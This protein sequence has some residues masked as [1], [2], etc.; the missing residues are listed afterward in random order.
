MVHTLFELIGS[1]A[2]IEET[3]SQHETLT[4]SI[5]TMHRIMENVKRHPDRY[6]DANVTYIEEFGRLLLKLDTSL[7]RRQMLASLSPAASTAL[8]LPWRL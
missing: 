3:I 4:G 7:M 2:A 1:V 6:N 5:H 8:I